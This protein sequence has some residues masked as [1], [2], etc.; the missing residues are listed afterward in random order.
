MLLSTLTIYIP[1]SKVKS[2]GR[3]EVS[4]LASTQDITNLMRWVEMEMEMETKS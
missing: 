4:H 1:V 3:L 2:K